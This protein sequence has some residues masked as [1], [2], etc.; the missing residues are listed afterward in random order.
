MGLDVLVTKEGIRGARL[1]ALPS[2]ADCEFTYFSNYK[3]LSVLRH[4]ENG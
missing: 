3:I 2:H 1:Q 4:R